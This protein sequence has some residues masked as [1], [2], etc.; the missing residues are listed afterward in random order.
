MKLKKALLMGLSLV[1]VAAIAVGGTLAFFTDRDSAANVFTVG[2]VSIE[3]NEKF[4]QGAELI[5]GVKI[6]KEV[7]V[8]NTGDNDAWVWMTYAIPSI[9][10]NTDANLNVIHVNTP[11]AYWYGYHTNPT[12]IASAGLTEAVDETDTWKVDY[13]VTKEVEIDGVMYNVYAHLYNGFLTAGETTNPGMNTVYLDS[14]V[15]I[16]PDGNMAWVEDGVAKDLNWNVNT[17]GNPVI[18]VSAYGIQTDGFATV[19]EAYAA[20]NEQWGD[21]GAE[22][23]P[24][25]TYVATAEGLK[26]ALKAAGAGDVVVLDEDITVGGPITVPA[27]VTLHGNGNS[28]KQT[29][30][31]V[32]DNA[33]L[34]NIVFEEIRDNE[35]YDLSYVYAD[36]VSV[37][38]D[39]CTFD[40]PDWDA[41]QIC[42]YETSD[43]TI[44]INNCTFTD[45]ADLAYRYIHIE[46]TKAIAQ[47]SNNGIKLVLT[48]NHFEDL[49]SCDEDGITI[50]GIYG[51]NMT[52]SGNTYTA[53]SE[54]AAYNECWLRVRNGNTNVVVDV[55]IF[56]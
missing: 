53:T 55:D 39:S 21:N 17:N 29:E 36:D 34:R 40:S 32:E 51:A 9:L 8:T 20:Y 46:T 27:G 43:H 44:V 50:Y 4:E 42:T 7:T 18:Y 52:I 54:E 16:D 23:A 47:D 5:P 24:V 28:L 31:Y 2:D 12:F 22:Y 33:T 45:S 48:N 3:L 26:S 10:D 19:E 56:E 30:V 11:G 35:K 41:L 14:H 25:G 13:A 37:T 49:D 15:D 1:L 38:I 6:E